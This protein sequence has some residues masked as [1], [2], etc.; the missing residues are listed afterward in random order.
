MKKNISIL[1]ILLFAV[2]CENEIP[3]NIK[4]NPPKLILNAFINADQESNDIILG[5]TGRDRATTLDKASVDVYVNGELK[6][7][8]TEPYS[9][10]NPY[11]IKDVRFKTHVAPQHGDIVKIEA[12]TDDGQY[13]VSSKVIVPQRITIENIDT[14]TVIKKSWWNGKDKFLRVKTTFTDDGR[15][16]NYYRIAISLDLE[17]DA[18]SIVTGADTLVYRTAKYPLFINE[19]IVLTDGRPSME[20]D[21][22]DILPPVENLWGIF[23][24]SRINGTYTMITTVQIPYMYFDSLNR[25]YEYP[26]TSHGQSTTLYDQIKTIGIKVR[27]ELMSITQE[28]FFYLK[29]LNI[30]DSV[31]YDDFFNLP[32]KFPSNIKDGTGIFGISIGDQT[33]IPLEDYVPDK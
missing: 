33:I 10:P 28:Q 30:Y 31:D 13:H 24:N 20:N 16:V 18:K 4:E 12:R 1:I 21:D 22:N 7:H 6:E 8:I 2:S 26:S 32:V 3:F 15:Q 14:A 27:L 9:M 23:D 5:L 25:G 19:D 29:A 11:G 17:I